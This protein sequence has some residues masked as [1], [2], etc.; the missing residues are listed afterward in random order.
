MAPPSIGIHWANERERHTA[1]VR[2]GRRIFPFCICCCCCVRCL[3]L[4]HRN[5]RIVCSALEAM[6][7]R[8]KFTQKHTHSENERETHTQVQF[9]ERTRCIPRAWLGSI[10]FC[11]I[12]WPCSMWRE[13]RAL[14][15]CLT[16]GARTL[17]ARLNENLSKCMGS[18]AFWKY[19]GV[20]LLSGNAIHVHIGSWSERSCLAIY[21]VAFCMLHVQWM[22]FA[23]VFLHA[24]YS[25]YAM[26][27]YISVLSYPEGIAGI[28]PYISIPLS[29]CNHQHSPLIRPT[30]C[31]PN[32]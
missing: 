13:R 10:L 11:S 28:I 5:V 16:R 25:M 30:P 19:A 2:F 7:A 26:C 18:C 24:I 29:S 14:P 6:R 23:L 20:P 12:L 22:P 31:I 27:K 32:P 15:F 1:A 3:A 17:H 4:V 8:F 9:S 21:L